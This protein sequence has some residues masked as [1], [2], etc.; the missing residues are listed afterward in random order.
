M[1]P[2]RKPGSVIL[3]RLFEQKKIAASLAAEVGISQ[4]YLS[5]I[6][7]G[8]RPGQKHRLAIAQA[9]DLKYEDIWED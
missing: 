2:K 3:S 5:Q 1:N 4:A 8:I 7:S 6:M 9:L